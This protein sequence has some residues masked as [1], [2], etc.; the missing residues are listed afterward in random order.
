MDLTTVSSFTGRVQDPE[1]RGRVTR[2]LR[3]CANRGLRPGQ[4]PSV[5]MH[6]SAAQRTNP[7]G[8]GHLPSRSPG[9]AGRARTVERFSRVLLR[10]VHYD[11]T[12]R[13]NIRG[14][15]CYFYRGQQQPRTA[16]SR[17]LARPCAGGEGAGHHLRRARGREARPG[18]PSCSGSV[19]SR[20]PSAI[21]D[22]RPRPIPATSPTV[23]PSPVWGNYLTSERLR[24]A[25]KRNTSSP[26]DC[27]RAT[28]VRHRLHVHAKTCSRAPRWLRGSPARLSGDVQVFSSPV[29]YD[30]PCRTTLPRSP[31]PGVTKLASAG[32]TLIRWCSLASSAVA[33]T[34]SL[35]QHD[36]FGCSYP[37]EPVH[38]PRLVRSFRQYRSNLAFDRSSRLLRPDT[39]CADCATTRRAAP[40]HGALHA[41]PPTLRP[42][43][44]GSTTERLLASGSVATAVPPLPAS[45]R[46]ARRGSSRIRSGR[47]ATT[48]RVPVAPGNPMITA[49]SPSTNLVRA[50]PAHAALTSDPIYDVTDRCNLRCNGIVL[51]PPAGTGGREE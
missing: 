47:S 5:A 33:H 10:G 21:A 51:L 27:T 44:P 2:S 31:I 22:P 18:P 25:A 50:V 15:G 24:R 30:G 11:M 46:A 37:H 1:S 32:G 4:A 48:V 40:R 9:R 17:S 13:C 12:R 42:S 3:P 49:R 26:V 35:G 28:T 45:R 7:P 6:A 8:E 34:H 38:H 23:S 36:L 16:S 14:A 41:T 20:S 19:P 29:G 43:G 39:D